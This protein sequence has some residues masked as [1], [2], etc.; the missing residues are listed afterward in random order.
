MTCEKSLQLPLRFTENEQNHWG[1]AIPSFGLDCSGGSWSKQ[2]S[3]NGPCSPWDS[4]HQ[5]GIPLTG[6]SQSCCHSA[7]AVSEE[8]GAGVGMAS[9]N[10]L[11]G[12][13]GASPLPAVERTGCMVL[14]WL[15]FVGCIAVLGKLFLNLTPVPVTNG[16][17]Y[18]I[19]F[20][21]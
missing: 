12:R 11:S 16:L 17:I 5:D 1:L 15:Q 21:F 18:S 20:Y 6:L 3:L 9:P 7:I 14:M 2:E 4:S 10:S 8:T 19:N 13:G